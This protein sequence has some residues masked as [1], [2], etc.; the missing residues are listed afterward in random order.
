MFDSVV[1]LIDY[2]VGN[3]LQSVNSAVFKSDDRLKSYVTAVDPK[4]IKGEWN[5]CVI[6]DVRVREIT[7]DFNS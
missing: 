6:V 3:S 4:Q 7:V 5:R 2:Y 1:E